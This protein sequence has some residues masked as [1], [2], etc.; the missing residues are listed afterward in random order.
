M[1]SLAVPADVDLARWQARAW[2]WLGQPRR[3]LAALDR[4]LAI[5]PQDLPAL[6]RRS[7]LRHQTGWLDGALEDARHLVALQP[8]ADAT[9]WFNLGYLEEQ[10]GHVARAAAAFERA[11]VLKPA[12]DTA[13]YGLG[14]ARL[15]LGELEAARPALQRCTELQPFSPHAWYQL[16]CVAAESGDAAEAHRIVA[17]LQGFEPAVASQLRAELKLA[18]AGA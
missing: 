1:N 7:W 16:A 3:A 15:R 2:V 13:W 9:A 18:G 11:T 10:A 8:E 12:L 4:C 14:L 6:A 5:N 17:H